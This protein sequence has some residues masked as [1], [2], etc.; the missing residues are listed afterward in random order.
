MPLPKGVPTADQEALQAPS[1]DP[2]MTLANASVFGPV[3]AGKGLLSQILLSS[4][5]GWAGKG[6]AGQWVMGPNEN[7]ARGQLGD[8]ILERIM[9]S[10]TGGQPVGNMSEAQLGQVLDYKKVLDWVMR[11]KGMFQTPDDIF[12]FP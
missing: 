12:P 9:Q 2:I 4:T 11:T 5:G 6:N 3:A 1:V 10:I 8:A 7:Q